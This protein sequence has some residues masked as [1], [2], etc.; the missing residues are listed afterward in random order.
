MLPA[1]HPQL[2]LRCQPSAD[3]HYTSVYN[4]A[5]KAQ[6]EL[7]CRL[8]GTGQLNSDVCFG[9]AFPTI[10]ICFRLNDDSTYMDVA[11]LP[12]KCTEI[13]LTDN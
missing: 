4:T 2:Q 12:E 7:W 13:F 5:Y 3:K 11:L 6:I 10:L 8:F 1:L 9:K